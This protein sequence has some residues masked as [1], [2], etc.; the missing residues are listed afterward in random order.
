VNCGAEGISRL[1][2]P[3]EKRDTGLGV[4]KGQEKTRNP[5]DLERD[6]VKM[7]REQIYSIALFKEV[8]LIKRLLKTRSGKSLRGTSKRVSDGKPFTVRPIIDDPAILDEVRAALAEK[9]FP[10]Y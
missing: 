4:V 1:P 3:Q 9:W 8:A 2:Q 6:L 10:K 5:A 7:V